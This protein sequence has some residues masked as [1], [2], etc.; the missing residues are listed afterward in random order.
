MADLRTN[1]LSFLSAS[2]ALGPAY[3]LPSSPAVSG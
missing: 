1:P 3:I 2:K